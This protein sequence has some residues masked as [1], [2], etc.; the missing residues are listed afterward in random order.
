MFAEFT[1]LLIEAGERHRELAGRYGWEQIGSRIVTS[2]W[3]EK[4]SATAY[5]AP[6]FR[7]QSRRRRRAGSC[8]IGANK[9]D[10]GL[11]GVVRLNR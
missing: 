5:Q 3:W 10:T 2:S 7:T 11:A 4:G 8:C 9:I 6:D 1:T